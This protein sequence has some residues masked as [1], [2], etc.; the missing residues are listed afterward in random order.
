MLWT[1]TQHL[2][3]GCDWDAQIQ[4]QSS[5]LTRHSSPSHFY[6]LFLW[7]LCYSL[8]ISSNLLPF[9]LIGDYCFYLF[10]FSCSCQTL[11]SD[12]FY[13]LLLTNLKQHFFNYKFIHILNSQIL[14]YVPRFQLLFTL[15]FV[16]VV[17]IWLIY[18]MYM[19]AD[20]V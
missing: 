7:L 20:C 17:E 3:L 8:P 4:I 13:T 14:F 5:S 12:W 9:S 19:Y 6:S 11:N 2:H 18:N 10:I 15:R 16:W 1:F